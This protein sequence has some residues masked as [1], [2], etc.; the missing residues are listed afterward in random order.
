MSSH[1]YQPQNTICIGFTTNN[2]IIMIFINFSIRVYYSLTTKYMKKNWLTSALPNVCIVSNILCCNI[3]SI[4]EPYYTE[5]LIY[6]HHLFSYVK[7]I[8]FPI[9][10]TWQNSFVATAGKWLKYPAFLYETQI[11]WLT[12]LPT[13]FSCSSCCNTSIICSKWCGMFVLSTDMRSSN[14]ISYKT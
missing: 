1:Y 8:S 6:L 9:Y 11:L 3:N 10:I 2:N 13:P 12:A 5:V 4:A 14:R 7:K